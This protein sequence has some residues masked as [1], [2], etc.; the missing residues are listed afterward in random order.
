MR[1][2]GL[3]ENRA[4]TLARGSGLSLTV[5]ARLIPGARAVISIG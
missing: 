1:S 3:D 4:L 2:M 5:L